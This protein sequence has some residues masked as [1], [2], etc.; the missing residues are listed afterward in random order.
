MDRVTEYLYKF[1]EEAAG[2]FAKHTEEVR[3][4][5]EFCNTFFEEGKLK[6]A[7]WSDFQGLRCLFCFSAIPLAG[8]RALGRQNHEIDQYRKS[9]LYLAHGPGE[10]IE[11]IRKLFSDPEYKLKFFGWAAIS[12]IAAYLW[13]DEFVLYNRKS[14]AAAKFLGLQIDPGRDQDAAEKLSSFSLALEPVRKSYLAIMGKQGGLPL[15]IEVDRFLEWIY[16]SQHEPRR[17]WLIS[18]NVLNDANP[19]PWIQRIGEECRVFLHKDNQNFH[20]FTEEISDGDRCLIAR[21]QGDSKKLLA[22]GAIATDAE[23]DDDVDGVFSRD[24]APFVPLG[25]SGQEVAAAEYGLDFPP[26]DFGGGQGR[27]LL[28]L[29]PDRA[30]HRKVIDFI[31]S[32]IEKVTA[33]DET[34]IVEQFKQ[35]ILQGP[36]GTGKTYRAIELAKELLGSRTINESEWDSLRF[37]PEKKTGR[38]ALV[39]FHPSYNYEDF[40]RGIQVKT[41]NGQVHYETVDRIFCSMAKKASQ[42]GKPHVLIIDEINRA[43]LPAVMGEL[44]YALEYRG[45]DVTLPYSGEALKVPE[46]FYVIGTMNTADR[47]IG[48]LDYAVR[49]RFAFIPCQPSEK[50]LENYPDY[51]DDN[52]RTAALSIFRSVSALFRTDGE[53]NLSPDF[54]RRDVGVGHT[55]FMAKTADELV[56]K[57]VF[58][59]LPL[60][61]EYIKDG[62]LRP[63]A[64]RKILLK[65]DEKSIDLARPEGQQELESA[66]WQILRR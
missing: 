27:A 19:Q 29:K 15:N 20:R 66:L 28:E 46:N 44:L 2:W 5:L 62:I 50:E 23:K 22:C 32:Q 48:Y 34:K 26:S 61:C 9:F 53:G 6:H 7:S 37:D 65:I 60:L 39:V 30:S 64:E 52:V 41:C 42:E 57:C 14:K 49:R 21:G 13:P 36:P 16:D 59:A 51:K 17:Y 35:V 8:T 55:Y 45:H 43:N 1:K 18:H 33:M 10:K 54:D 31:D 12:E 3:K 11:R 58:Q 38:W 40:L 56:R 24:L 25:G 63:D 4:N 47:S